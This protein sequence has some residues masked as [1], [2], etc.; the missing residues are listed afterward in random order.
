MATDIVDD[1]HSADP[2]CEPGAAKIIMGR[3]AGEI[4]RL[5]EHKQQSLT[6]IKEQQNEIEDMRATLDKS[7]KL[8]YSAVRAERKAILEMIEQSEKRAYAARKGA[9]TGMANYYDGCV[10]S[11]S[12]LAAAIKAR[13]DAG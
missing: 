12:L 5:R 3:A 6:L 10:D 4:E 9:K 11:L 2:E 8:A 13:G 7:A 1:L